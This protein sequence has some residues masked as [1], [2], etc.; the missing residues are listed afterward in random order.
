MCNLYKNDCFENVFI[1]RD[2]L[3]LLNIA[4]LQ[5]RNVYV[6][7]FSC[8]VTTAELFRMYFGSQIDGTVES[9]KLFWCGDEPRIA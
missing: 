6:C 5:I 9:Y 7:M 8:H 3:F 2:N 4:I 1:F